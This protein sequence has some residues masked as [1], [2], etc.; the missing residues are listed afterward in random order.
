[1]IELR[2]IKTSWHIIKPWTEKFDTAIK[3]KTFDLRAADLL[4]PNQIDGEFT[5]FYNLQT[6]YIEHFF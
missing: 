6:Y 3:K 5:C 1:M 2:R 4:L